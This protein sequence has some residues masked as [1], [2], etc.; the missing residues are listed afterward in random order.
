MEHTLP[1]P[2]CRPPGFLPL[3]GIIAILPGIMLLA[4]DTLDPDMF[5]HLRV[6]EQ[7][8]TEGIGPL[9]DTFSYSSVATPWTPYS[10]LA[11]IAMREIWLAG[12]YRAAL[13]ANAVL[14]AGILFFAAAT[15]RQS[16]PHNWLGAAAVS[17]M[18]FHLL[19][20]WLHFRPVTFGIFILSIILW[21][22]QRDLRTGEQTR[23]VWLI[24]PLTAL[25]TN[26]HL[27]AVMSPIW[28]GI[29]FINSY[30]QPATT[31][32]QLE[33]KELLRRRRRRLLLLALSAAAIGATPM[34]PGMIEAAL[35]YGSTD[36]MVACRNCNIEWLPL[37]HKG[38]FGMLELALIAALFLVLL[39]ILDKLTFIEWMALVVLAAATVE[40]GRTAP[41]LALCML[42][43]LSLS[44]QGLDDR[45]L[46][47]PAVTKGLYGFL[48]LLIA[49]FVWLIP[50]AH[51]S[52]EQWE[53]RSGPWYGFPSDAADFVSRNIQPNHG[54]LINDFGW[55]G[56]LGWRLGD[57]FKVLVDGRTQIYPA[58]F[59]QATVLGSEQQRKEYLS[60]ISADAA[61][62]PLHGGDF[63]RPLLQLGWREV[64]A[65]Q[66]AKV[67][68]PP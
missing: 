46:L 45:R 8:L 12:G 26:V 2:S 22:Q 10:W 11:E 62:L 66:K 25:A 57:R 7:L 15:A 33:C 55:G 24:V 30:L 18:V 36:P 61:I 3:I 29:H 52:M 63:E 38:W 32:P 19:V 6:A 53:T 65:D 40:H 20:P 1:P 9:V 34:L 47:D 17:A 28:M 59:W 48:G 68:A 13:L 51:L 54:R 64:Y 37:Y 41:L 4:L 5:W 16:A 60:R 44:V 31:I 49:A 21:L 56:Y 39:S 58:A 23:A 43:A 67:L 14:L 42:P 50:P 27:F 35:Y